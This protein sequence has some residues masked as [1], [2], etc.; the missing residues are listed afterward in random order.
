MKVLQ[1]FVKDDGIFPNNRLPIL[2]YKEALDLPAVFKARTIKKLFTKH[3]W[4]NNY[5]AGIFTYHH[6]HSNTHEVLGVIKGGTTVLLGGDE[7]Q[8]LKIEKG[9]VLIIPA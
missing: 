1:F 4:G 8:K 3:G 5:R 7:G 2:L 6:Y 9:D